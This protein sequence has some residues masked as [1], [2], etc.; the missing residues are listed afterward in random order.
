[1]SFK[2]VKSFFSLIFVIAYQLRIYSPLPYTLICIR[3]RLCSCPRDVDISK[4]DH[5]VQ[6]KSLVFELLYYGLYSSLFTYAISSIFDRS[7]AVTENSHCS[8]LKCIYTGV[9][10]GFLTLVFL[11]YL[12]RIL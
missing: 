7:I 5:R 2:R 12:I 1:M 4:A 9:L 6:I 3:R 10:H 8:S 11:C